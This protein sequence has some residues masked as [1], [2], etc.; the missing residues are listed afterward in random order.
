MTPFGEKGRTLSRT[1]PLKQISRRD[2]GRDLS[3]ENPPRLQMPGAGY[4][5]HT[6]VL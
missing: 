6:I 1:S 5:D 3:V 4:A 2:L